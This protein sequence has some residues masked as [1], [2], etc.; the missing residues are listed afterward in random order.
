MPVGV[1]IELPGPLVAI[2]NVA[3][4]PIHLCLY[5]VGPGPNIGSAEKPLREWTPV[6]DFAVVVGIGLSWAFYSSIAFLSIWF[7]RNRHLTE[8]LKSGNNKGPG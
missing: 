1:G 2:A 8:T 5:L 6:Q 7:H 4:W 3:L